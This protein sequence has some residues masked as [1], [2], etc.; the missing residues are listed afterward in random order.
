M[1]AHF[2]ALAEKLNEPA[3]ANRPRAEPEL[4]AFLQCDTNI[5][6]INHSPVTLAETNSNRSS[7]FDRPPQLAVGVHE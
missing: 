7:V 4:V 1:N 6:I 2:Y 3:S 5:A